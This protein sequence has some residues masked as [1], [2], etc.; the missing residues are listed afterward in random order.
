VRRVRNEAVLPIAQFLG[1]AWSGKPHLL[2]KL[3]KEKWEAPDLRELAEAKDAIILPPPSRYPAT[4][5]ISAYRLWRF[6]LFHEAM[7]HLFGIPDSPWEWYQVGFFIQ[8]CVEDYKVETLGTRDY[9]YPGMRKERLLRCAVYYHLAPVPL[10]PVEAF[11]QLLLLGAVKG[12]SPDPRV[13]EAVRYVK[14]H[15]LTEPSDRIAG[16]VC[17]ILGVDPNREFP[18]AHLPLDYP[19]A[20]TQRLKKDQIKKAVED[21]LK[22]L[23]EQEGALKRA[24]ERSEE[25]GKTGD[26]EGSGGDLK[27]EVDDILKTPEEIKAEISEMRKVNEKLEAGRKGAA[28]EVSKGVYLPSLLDRDESPYYD[29]ELINHLVAQL[30]RVRKGW[31]EVPSYAGE[32]DVEGYISRYSKPFLD[33][34]RLKVGGFRVLIL[35]DHSGS[36]ASYSYKYK[37][38][39]VALAEALSELKISFAV[40]A[41]GA[42]TPNSPTIIWL[43]KSFD[44]PWTRLCAKRLAQIPAEGGTPL[45][46][47]YRDLLPVVQRKGQGKLLFVTL[48]DGEPGS[49]ALTKLEVKH[50]KKYCRMVAIAIGHTMDEAVRL[51][52]NLASLGYDRYVALDNLRKLPEKVLK[53]LGEQM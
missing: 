14:E 5:L 32:L 37:K 52:Q 35:L 27:G 19:V 38:A 22:A 43:I 34:E 53:L 30:R 42:P 11:A 48:T 2:V 21:Y 3:Y 26:E 50:L 36:I 1:R 31:R 24:G 12:V 15:F 25:S 4:D 41:F 44:E 23:R 6:S 39:C 18:K 47:V 45:D 29:E 10:N 46:K 40:Y 20:L 13:V 28:S 33:E 51:A 8:N 7:H 49:A 16:E 9:A 17:R